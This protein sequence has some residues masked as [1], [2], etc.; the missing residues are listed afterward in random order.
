MQVLDDCMSCL[1]QFLNSF[2]TESPCKL[3]KSIFFLG[4]KMGMASKLCQFFF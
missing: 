2:F 1:F 4:R 3:F